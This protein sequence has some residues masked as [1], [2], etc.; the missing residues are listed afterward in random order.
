L[1]AKEARVKSSRS[2]VL[3][4]KSNSFTPAPSSSQGAKDIADAFRVDAPAW[5]AEFKVVR[6]S[7]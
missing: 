2:R 3:Y 6:D 7:L 1:I 4:L 5:V